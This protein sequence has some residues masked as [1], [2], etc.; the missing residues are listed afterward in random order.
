MYSRTRTTRAKALGQERAGRTQGPRRP[1][2]GE[3]KQR[4]MAQSLRYRAW[5]SVSWK[6]GGQL[7]EQHHPVAQCAALE[8]VLSMPSSTAATMP[9]W[10]LST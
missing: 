3:V 8:G 5:C 6:G 9:V 2:W 7:V 1:M 4:L 10:L